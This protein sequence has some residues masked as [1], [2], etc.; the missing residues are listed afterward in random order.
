MY[1]LSMKVA[2]EREGRFLA[3]KM[4]RNKELISDGLTYLPFVVMNRLTLIHTL[5][6]E[7]H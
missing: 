6:V 4:T 3:K 7:N 5:S 2:H 1:G